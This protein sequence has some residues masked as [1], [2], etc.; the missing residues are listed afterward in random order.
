MPSMQVVSSDLVGA[1]RIPPIGRSFLVYATLASIANGNT[2]KTY[3][4]R[5]FFRSLN[6]LSHLR[7]GKIL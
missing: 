7:V 3:A 5:P 4:D 2:G 1:L 6:I